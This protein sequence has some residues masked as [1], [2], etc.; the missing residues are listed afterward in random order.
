MT[1][2]SSGAVRVRTGV[3]L[4]D[5]SAEVPGIKLAAFLIEVNTST[6]S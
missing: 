3:M 6:Y 1:Y 4:R 2:S 5:N